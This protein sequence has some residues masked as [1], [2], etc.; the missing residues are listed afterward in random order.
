MGIGIELP[1]QEVMDFFFEA[2]T[3]TYAG[4][5][6]RTTIQE[7]PGSRVLVYERGPYRYVDYYYSVGENSFGQIA[8]WHEALPAGPIWG[9]Q[10][11][12]W[13]KDKRVIP[14]LKRT[15]VA[16]YEQRI[17]LGGRGQQR[18]RPAGATL[19]YQ[20][21]LLR[22]GNFSDSEGAEEIWDSSLGAKALFHHDYNCFA[23]VKLS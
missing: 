1:E 22:S 4:G 11:R 20:N 21:H 13:C 23:L 18:F 7:L 3:K 10:Y 8:I 17:F 12:G 5:M 14:F 19:V 2:G 6:A 15:L 9:M 16:A